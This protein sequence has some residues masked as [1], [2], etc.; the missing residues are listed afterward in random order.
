M[1]LFF[2]ASNIINYNKDIKQWRRYFAAVVLL[3]VTNY[4]TLARSL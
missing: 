4:Q 1:Q 3:V 2:D